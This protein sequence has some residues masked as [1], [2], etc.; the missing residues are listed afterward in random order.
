MYVTIKVLVR[1][2]I[3]E[4]HAESSLWKY[5]ITYV[6][7]TILNLSVFPVGDNVY[8]RLKYFLIIKAYN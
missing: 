6:K 7:D 8:K 1:K 4:C 3:K 2:T 5:V